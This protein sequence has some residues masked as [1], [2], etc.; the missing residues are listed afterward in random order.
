MSSSPVVTPGLTYGVMKSRILAA[1]W[2]AAR[3]LARSAGSVTMPM[4]QLEWRGR[5]IVEL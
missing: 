5:K 2:Q 4:Y 3:I 1:S